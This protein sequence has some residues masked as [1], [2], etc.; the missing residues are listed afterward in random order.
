LASYITINGPERSKAHCK[1]CGLTMSILIVDTEQ[2]S[3]RLTPPGT[4]SH[5]IRE[6]ATNFKLGMRE[7]RSSYE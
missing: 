6:N 7:R 3:Y 2:R 4:P 5:S 1:G